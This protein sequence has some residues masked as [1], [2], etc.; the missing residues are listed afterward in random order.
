MRPAMMRLRVTGTV[1][2]MVCIALGLTGCTNNPELG[3]REFAD[4]DIP[5]PTLHEKEDLIE[6]IELC[7]EHFREGDPDE[8]EFYYANALFDHPDDQYDYV[9]I[10]Q[11]ADVEYGHPGILTRDED[12]NA[13]MKIIARAQE[14]ELEIMPGTWFEADD[15]CAGCWE[16]TREYL[17][18][19]TIC[20]GEETDCLGSQGMRVRFIAGPHHKDPAKWAIYVAEDLPRAN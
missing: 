17:I 20:R 6:T 7:Y 5:W 2:G 18:S 13:T 12:I 9:W 11:E 4:S 19:L 8:I 14:L 15:V 10:M 1:V 16:T 3:T